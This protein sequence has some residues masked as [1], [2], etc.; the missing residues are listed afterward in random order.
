MPANEIIAEIHRHREALARECGYNVK[1]LMDYYRQR[2]AERE[3]AGHELVSFVEPAADQNLCALREEP[4]Q[5]P[6]QP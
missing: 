6:G 3:T 2:E 1:T 5:K 4:P